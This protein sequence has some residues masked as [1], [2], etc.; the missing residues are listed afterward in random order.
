MNKR[1]Q[2]PVIKGDTEGYSIPIKGKI[3]ED[4]LSILNIHTPITRVLVSVKENQ[5]K[6]KSHTDP[7]T[8]AVGDFNSTLSP[9]DR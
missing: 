6:L 8:L 9:M 4:E 7:Q 2:Q 3:H 1:F 5:L